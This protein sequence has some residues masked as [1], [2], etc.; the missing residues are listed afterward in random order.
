MNIRNEESFSEQYAIISYSHAD[1]E[2]VKAELSVFDRHSIC[3]WYDERMTGGSGFDTQFRDILDNDNCKGI[4][5]FVSSPFLLSEPCAEEMKYFKEKYGLGKSGKFCLFVMADGYPYSDADA[6]YDC[7]DQY[8]HEREDAD[9]RK[10]LRR[11]DDHIN[12]F[13]ELNRGGKEIFATIGNKNG[14]IK[15]YCEEGQLFFDAG[16][17]FGHKQIENETFGFFPQ[18]QTR[19]SGASETEKRSE[20]CYADAEPAY[21]APVEWIVIKDSDTEQT[22]LSKELLFAVD[23]L[24]LKHPFKE[25]AETVEEQIGKLFLKYF[26][27]GDDGEKQIKNVRFLSEAE[28]SALLRRYQRDAKKRQEILLPEATYYA[29]V[30]RRKN[31][32]AFWLAG[33]TNDARR[34]D[35]A[36]EALAHQEAIGVELYYVRIV[37]EV[38]KTNAQEEADA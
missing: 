10:K 1:T 35:A 29:Q 18:K 28:L 5:F 17:L 4:I 12:T 19:R 9:I 6:I 16:I 2:T 21:Y 7:L 32:F 3:Y 8:A 14:Y 33:D 23:Y 31:T 38:E 13:L 26:I 27:P 15:T 30:S 37:L 24:S 36:T 11:A 20:K 25:T 34:V 22:L